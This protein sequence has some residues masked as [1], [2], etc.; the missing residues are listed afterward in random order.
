VRRCRPHRRRT[1]YTPLQKRVLIRRAIQ[2]CYKQPHPNYWRR[3][4][5]IAAQMILAEMPQ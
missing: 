4:E 2:R 3:L 1:H 5:T